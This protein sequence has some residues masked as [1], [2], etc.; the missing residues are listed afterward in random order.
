ME[1]KTGPK[2]W[3]MKIEKCFEN[4]DKIL[5]KEC[6]TTR[7]QTLLEQVRIDSYWLLIQTTSSSNSYL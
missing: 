7:G 3:A 5:L 6:H 2:K 4:K 1:D